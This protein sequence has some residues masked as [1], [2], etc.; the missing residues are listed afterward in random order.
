MIDVID[1]IIRKIKGVLPEETWDFIFNTFEPHQVQF[2]NPPYEAVR[3]NK[4]Y[5][6]VKVPKQG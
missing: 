2:N 5:M 1:T 4:D 6:L 3:I